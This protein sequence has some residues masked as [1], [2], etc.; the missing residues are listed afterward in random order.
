MRQP[1]KSCRILFEELCPPHRGSHTRTTRDP[2]QRREGA[3]RR[4]RWW[5]MAQYNAANDTNIIKAGTPRRIPRPVPDGWNIRPGGALAGG[6]CISYGVG[7]SAIRATTAAI[8]SFPLLSVLIYVANEHP[9][10]RAG[11]EAAARC[12]ERVACHGDTQTSLCDIDAD[13]QKVLAV[14]LVILEVGAVADL[15][16]IINR[17]YPAPRAR[18]RCKGPRRR[19]GSRGRECGKAQVPE[20]HG[21]HPWGGA[22]GA[23]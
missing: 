5:M 11:V 3:K 22:L 7:L 23:L 17:V 13:G 19:G 4:P 16:G 2:A 15:D 1:Q 14:L 20:V 6:T 10:A 9:A 12:G 8:G 18:G 21:C